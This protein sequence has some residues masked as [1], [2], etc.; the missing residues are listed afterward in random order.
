MTKDELEEKLKNITDNKKSEY[1]KRLTTPYIKN[2]KKKFF[3]EQ[4]INGSGKELE[5]KFWSKISS[6]RIAFDLYSCLVNDETVDDF[7]FEYKLPGISYKKV[8]V[9]NMDVYYQEGTTIYF[10]E[11]KFTETPSSKLPQ[12]YYIKTDKYKNT[13]DVYVNEPLQHRF[14]N[15]LFIAKLF[16]DFCYKYLDNIT[17]NTNDWFDYK[18]EICHLF[19]II[20]YAKENLPTST[21]KQIDFRNI[22][23]D[24]DDYEIIGK[25]HISQSA[26]KFIHDATIMVNMIFEHEKIDIKFSY[27]YDFIQSI[28]PDF[29]NKKAYGTD[30]TVKEIMK[31]YF[32][33]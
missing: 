30:I 3:F 22:V 21:I 12:A 8:G 23:Y 16:S 11:S 5:K 4:Y 1:L 26:L 13:R 14:R 28:L 6:S 18:Q 10:I 25:D 15:N 24:F 9:P 27:D 20:F 7:E 2:G 17:K 31:Q 33:D 32:I 29:E 19:G